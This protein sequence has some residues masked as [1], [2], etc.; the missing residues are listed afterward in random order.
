[1]ERRDFLKKTAL[2]AA[3]TAAGATSAEATSTKPGVPDFAGTASTP[4]ANAQQ[5]PPRQPGTFAPLPTTTEG[6]MKYRIL[7]D[8]GEKVSIIGIGGFHL[9][10]PGGATE[11]EA[12]R[13]VRTGID[14]G[15]NFC[16][17]SWDYNGGESEKRLGLA[18]QD[19]YRDKVFLMTKIDGRTAKAAMGQL[20]TSLKRLKTDHLDLLQFHEIIRT[21]D[22]PRIFAPGGALEAVLRAK[23]QGKL[24]F[25]GF[26]G[27]KSPYIHREMF[28]T[29][30]ANHFHFDTVQ[31]PVNIMD[32][33]FDSFQ[34]IILP[35]AE[36]QRTAVLAMKTFGDK[37]IYQSRVAA[38]I[39][40]LHYSMSQ[41]VAVV[42]TGIDQMLILD[43]ALEAVRTY[44]PM[45]EAEQMA[46]LARSAKVG[47]TGK[48]EKYKVSE[49]FDS[50]AKNPQWL[51]ET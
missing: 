50:T 27:H 19:G 44:Q 9:A 21:D 45:S 25:I 17:N 47:A 51:T 43:Q 42:I 20:E 6:G 23:E 36:A 2:A 12:I 18:L 35:I 41:P 3:T 8:T 46:L 7:G 5:P 38:P 22:P 24:R 34:S 29:A 31:M 33:H 10:K 1:M 32:A 28:E 30:E 39:E 49:H 15:L 14:K 16:D 4:A 48:T 40:M 26:T 37:F 13:I 11:A